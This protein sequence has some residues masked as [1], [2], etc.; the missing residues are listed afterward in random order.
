MTLCSVVGGCQ[1][2]ELCFALILV[3][4]SRINSSSQNIVRTLVCCIT[5]EYFH[6]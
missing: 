4:T 1:N 5:L 6:N 2:E 3:A